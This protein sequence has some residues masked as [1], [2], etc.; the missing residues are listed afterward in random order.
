MG[1]RLHQSSMTVCW[2]GLG[3][4]V[5][6]AALSVRTH[7]AQDLL[8]VHVSKQG[9]AR[10]LPRVIYPQVQ[11]APSSRWVANAPSA[12]MSALLDTSARSPCTCAAA[13]HLSSF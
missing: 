9:F 2:E 5:H 4:A 6:A 12:A 1:F 10:H 13:A 11:S 7:D 3:H 8:R